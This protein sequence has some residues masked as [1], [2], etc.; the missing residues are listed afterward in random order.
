MVRDEDFWQHRRLRFQAG[1]QQ[2]RQCGDTGPRLIVLKFVLKALFIH[3]FKP[4]LL[5]IHGF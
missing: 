4:L 1:F 2:E 3:P 5:W